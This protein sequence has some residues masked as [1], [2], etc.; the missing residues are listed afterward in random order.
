MK[1]KILNFNRIS[2]TVPVME[3]DINKVLDMGSLNGVLADE[4]TGK[5]NLSLCLLYD[6]N[7]ES[8]C[9]VKIYRDFTITK[10]EDEVNELIAKHGLVN[11]VLSSGQSNFFLFLFLKKK[12]ITNNI[13]KDGA[14]DG[15]EKS[16]K[17]KTRKNK[18]KTQGTN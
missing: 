13:R 1:M 14:C 15:Q 17:K 2:R 3:R 16:K 5:T 9:F 4:A 7:T 11:A 12:A 6:E 10:Y 18:A 8:N